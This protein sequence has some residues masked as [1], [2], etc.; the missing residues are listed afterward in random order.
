MDILVLDS[1]PKEFAF[2]QQALG[3]KKYVLTQVFSSGQVWQYVQAG[4]PRFLIADW[5]GSDLARTQVLQRVRALNN[6]EPFYALLI[7]SKNTEEE[8]VP[9][10]ADDIIQRPLRAADLRNRVALGERIIS[11]AGHLATARDQLENH[12]V[13]DRLTGFM[14][15]AAFLHQAAGELERSRRASLPLSLIAL[16]IDNFKIINDTFGVEM[17]DNVLKVVA[18]SIREK[19]RPYDCIG[20]WTGDEFVIALPGVIGADAEK[21]SERVIAG[22]RGT[23]IEVPNEP[24]LNVKISAGIASVARISTSSEIEPIIQQ[25]RQAVTRA[26]ESG[27]NQVFLIFL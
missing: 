27:G 26:K 9:S 23:R 14:N 8:P 3:G 17:G 4:Q 25:A 16:D 15:R 18:Q 22:V 1:D 7:T 20:R 11:L 21:V 19:S 24:P 12:A 5:D 2:I 13:F 10:G 6:A